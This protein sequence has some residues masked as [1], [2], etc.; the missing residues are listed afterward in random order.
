MHGQNH[1]KAKEMLLRPYNIKFHVKP[2]KV[3]S[4]YGLNGPGIDIFLPPPKLPEGLWGHLYPTQS[5]PEF[6]SGGKVAE[7]WN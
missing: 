1:I 5:V 2:V 6:F 4:V 3:Q 7:D